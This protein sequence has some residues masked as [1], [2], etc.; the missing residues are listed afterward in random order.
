LGPS[1][2]EERTVAEIKNTSV[3]EAQR[4]LAEEGYSY[5][6]VRTEEEFE[7]GHVPGAL[8]V[9]INVQGP[10]GMS[11]NPD[12]VSVMEGGFDKDQKLIVGCKAGGRAIR[13]ATQLTQSGFS[14][15]V[16]MGAGFHGSLA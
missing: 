1:R 4:L 9:P 2:N 14:Q 6:D 8:N 13:A 11:A 15:I 7:A 16:V 3:E 10:G 12:F 5:L